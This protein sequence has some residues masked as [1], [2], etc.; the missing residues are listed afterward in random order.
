[1]HTKKELDNYK[2]IHYKFTITYCEI[3]NFFTYQLSTQRSILIILCRAEL[4]ELTDMIGSPI[5]DTS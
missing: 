3:I 2:L 4:A 1:M 5:D